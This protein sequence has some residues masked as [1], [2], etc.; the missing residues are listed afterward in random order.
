MRNKL[1]AYVS[2]TGPNGS[3]WKVELTTFDVTLFLKNGWKE[4]V[5]AHFLEENDLLIFKFIGAS[6]FDVSVFN[7]QSSCEKQRS[8][9]I[10][11]Y[12]HINVAIGSRR[13]WPIAVSN[14]T[15]IGLS[16]DWFAEAIKKIRTKSW[17]Y[18]FLQQLKPQT[19]H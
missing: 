5:D 16:E 1:E 19:H 8:F 4:F 17:H 11:W 6:R 9:Y 13:K 18:H 15:T 3:T 7:S 14:D 10:E 2:L 12:E